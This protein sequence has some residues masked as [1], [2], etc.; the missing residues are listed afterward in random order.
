MNT[1][2][3]A[4]LLLTVLLALPT[5]GQAQFSYTTN[6]GAITIT[7]PSC[8]SGAA[9][10]PS[11]INGLPVTAIGTNAFEFCRSLTSVIISNS[12][13]SIGAVAFWN[14]TSLTSVTIGTNVSNIG[15]YAFGECAS[16]TTVTIPNS[17]TNLGVD[18]FE[19]C[20]NLTTVVIGGR[21][22]N[23][24]DY[25]FWY[26]TNLTGV[27]FRGNAPRLGSY[28]FSGD[29]K[30]TVYYLPG[31][32]GWG[33]TFGGR[34][35]AL[36]PL[37]YWSY[38]VNSGAIAVTGYSGPGGAVIIP[39]TIYGLPVTSIASNTF[40]AA[41]SLTSVTIGNSVTSIGSYAFSGCTNLTGIYF[42]SNAPSL[43]SSVFASDANATV[44]YSAGTTG[45]ASTFAGLPT[46][47][48]D[49]QVPCVYK[50]SNGAIT[51]TKYIGSKGEVGIPPTMVGLPVTGI[52]TNAF[53]GGTSLTSVTIGNSVTSIGS[54]A[55]SGCTNLTEIYFQ[56][57]APSLGS[58]VFASDTN[59]I[60]YYL[61]GTAGWGTTFGGRPAVLWDPKVLSSGGT[62]GVRTN[63]FG[64][65]IVGTSNL[66]IVVEASTNLANPAWLAVGTNTLTQGSSYFS[67][68]R[69]TN[70]PARFYRL[71]AP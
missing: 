44:Y 16:L 28:V 19:Y 59:T 62:F 21:V 42:Q 69:W 54:Y 6:K 22:T 66:V 50:A 5:L 67:D 46:G 30:A 17:V 61:S 37:A 25:A 63:R 1:R 57:N 70:Y 13:T 65:T 24:G 3:K 68:P 4:L 36:W 41:T 49:P 31:T 40:Q 11:S 47:L 58:S 7:Y 34:P 64:F 27:Y 15:D 18:A 56:G 38:T 23:I 32:T 53:S 52:G 39:N 33:A 71:R 20:S 10:I 51:I 29:N 26:C 45:W 9:F 55:F 2:L 60:I 14:C 8:L 48:W 43:G 35:T 12:V